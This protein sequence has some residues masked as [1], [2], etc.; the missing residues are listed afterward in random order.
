MSGRHEGLRI[1]AQARA[2]APDLWVVRTRYA[3]TAALT[4]LA[5][6]LNVLAPWPLKLV[7]DYLVSDQAL[8]WPAALA[9]SSPTV[10]VVTLGASALAIAVAS[11]FVESADGVWNARTR[12]RLT[13]A[14]R[15]RLLTHL[16]AL[17]PTIRSTHRSGELVLRLVGDVD[18]FARLSTK[19]LPQLAR[20]LL[21]AI[22]TLAGMWW[23]SPR[24]ALASLVMLVVLAGLVRH[25]GAR[26][27]HTS[28]TKRRREGAVSALAQEIV[29]G[30]PVIQAIGGTDGARRR[31]LQASAES[32]EAGV[33]ASRAAA[34]LERAFE[35]ARGATIAAVTAGGALLVLRDAL[36]VG[37]LTVVCAYVA[38]LLR[39]IDRIN[40]LTEA[41]SRGL[42]AGERLRSLLDIV[43]IVR[44]APGA[45]ASPSTEGRIEFAGVCFTYPSD[46]RPRPPVLR[47]ITL[48]F[49]R[50]RLA[51][52]V[53]QS[54]AGKSTV[55]SLLL[56]LF[57]PTAGEI[58]LDGRPLADYTIASL[59]GHVAVMTQDLHLFSGTLRDALLLDA[60]PVS[61]EAIGTA[62]AQVALTDLVSSLPLGLDT[63]LGEDGVNLSGGQRQRLSLARAF[64]LD[65]P[66]L[67]L[68]EPLANVDAESAGVILEA[69]AR[70]KP[71]RTCVAITYESALVGLAD[72]VYRLAHG[73]IVFEGAVAAAASAGR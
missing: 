56:R 18:Q 38:Q 69:I 7:I 12:E 16:A 28:R 41:A 6:A 3:V 27:S 20:H 73:R 72:D 21:T 43:P 35:L 30:L 29:R 67:L 37:E 51:V 58:R 44:D 48:R 45:L 61:A 32:L 59:R 42:V 26:M 55:F 49:E 64:L 17:P 10:V 11:A 9:S 54:G 52:I 1:G 70:L 57:D 34:Q 2:F 40:D 68:D 19:T 13:H 23:L 62:L 8:R 15:D 46:A 24:L 60:S 39:P 66:I 36:T 50:G 22:G 33:A 47:G 14:L 53:G 71:G 31:F 4:T 65:R 25:F 63:P 5:V